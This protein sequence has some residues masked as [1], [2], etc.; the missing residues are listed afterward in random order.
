MIWKVRDMPSRQIWWLGR[1]AIGWPANRISP[2][3]GLTVPVITLNSV[4]LPAP[5][6]PMTARTSPSSTRH[7]DL[8]ERDQGAVASRH[9]VELEQR[10][11]QG[12]GAARTPHRRV[13]ASPQ[14]PFGREQDEGDEDQA[15]V[16]R[17]GLRPAR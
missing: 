5:L 6:G 11:V 8:V 1:P 15:E 3:V 17:P 14:M 16:E 2:A 7:G 13:V 4:V 10:H 9:A 12:L